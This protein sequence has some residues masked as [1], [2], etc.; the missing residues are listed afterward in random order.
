M[1]FGSDPA[2]KADDGA[3]DENDDMNSEAR[4]DRFL[5]GK[6]NHEKSG[7]PSCLQGSPIPDS[8]N[9]QGIGDDANRRAK[10]HFCERDVDPESFHIGIEGA[11]DHDPRSQACQTDR[12]MSMTALDG[13]KIFC[14]VTHFLLDP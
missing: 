1:F 2:E 3:D 5:F 10:N 8:A 4:G 9:R 14:H 11:E 7:R 6:P 13:V 12:K